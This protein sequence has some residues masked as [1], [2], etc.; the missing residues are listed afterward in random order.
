V[1]DYDPYD[2]T[3][4]RAE[5]AAIARQDRTDH[6]LRVLLEQRPAV[7]AQPGQLRPEVQTWIDGYLAGDRG[8]L[9]LI[10]EIGTGK[11]WS[12]WK[13]AEALIA[14]GWAGRFEI[15]AAYEIKE[16]TDRPV[17]TAQLRRWREAD[18]FAID[19][20]GA[21]R[22]YDWDADALAALIDKRWQHHRPLLVASNET[23]LKTIVGARAASRLVDNATFVPFAGQDRRRNP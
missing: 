7:F 8:S 19:D 11:T 4:A 6:R 17:N 10:G 14:S 20:L 22:V 1:T 15:A 9:L 12:L 16:A 23:D 18:L 2:D 21:Q 3:A 13:T 5:A